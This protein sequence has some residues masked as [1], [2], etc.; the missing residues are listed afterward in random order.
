MKAAQERLDEAFSTIADPDYTRRETDAAI[1]AMTDLAREA[2]A[3]L[4]RI[5]AR[6]IY[7]ESPHGTELWN[8]LRRFLDGE[9]EEKK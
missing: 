9:Q 2:I 6:A 1:E 7:D 3:L 5:E 4:R 8:A